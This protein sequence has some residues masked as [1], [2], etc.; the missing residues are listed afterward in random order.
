MLCGK[1]IAVEGPDGRPKLKYCEAGLNMGWCP[2]PYESFKIFQE[3]IRYEHVNMVDQYG[4]FRIDATLPPPR[5][6]K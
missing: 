2:G 3:K 4:L 5:L 6:K 1:L